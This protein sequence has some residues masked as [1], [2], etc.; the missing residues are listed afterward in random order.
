M[1]FF[2]ETR[3]KQY[4]FLPPFPHLF[5]LSFAPSPVVPL[6]ELSPGNCLTAKLQQSNDKHK[7]GEEEGN[8]I[9]NA[10]ACLRTDPARGTHHNHEVRDW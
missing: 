4:V 2:V 1:L 10:D 6:V 9:L 8:G 3:D 5:F 7:D